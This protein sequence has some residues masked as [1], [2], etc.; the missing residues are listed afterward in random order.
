M[1]SEWIYQ[2]QGDLLWLTLILANLSWYQTYTKSKSY[3]RN[4][5]VD[6]PWYRTSERLPSIFLILSIRSAVLLTIELWIYKGTR[7]RIIERIR[8]VI[9]PFATKPVTSSSEFSL[10]T[11]TTTT[12]NGSCCCCVGVKFISFCLVWRKQK[13]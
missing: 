9:D 1:V 5:E 8:R 2:N 4:E 6:V 12:G 10:I 13:K 11:T 3:D 7:R